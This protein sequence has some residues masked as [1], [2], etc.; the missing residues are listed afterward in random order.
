MFVRLASNDFR[1][2]IQLITQSF[3]FTEQILI[4]NNVVCNTFAQSNKKKTNDDDADG[5]LDKEK[6]RK[7]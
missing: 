3:K 6:T 1:K 7:N 4:T 2:S 5:P